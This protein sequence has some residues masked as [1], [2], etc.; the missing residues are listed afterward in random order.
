MTISLGGAQRARRG[1]LRPPTASDQSL[2][3]SLAR[4][5]ALSR[6]TGWL[7]PGRPPDRPALHHCAASDAPLSNDPRRLALSVRACVRACVHAQAALVAR[8]AP[9]AAA[10][11]GGGLGGSRLDAAAVARICSCFERY[12]LPTRLPRQL[13]DVGQM[14]CAVLADDL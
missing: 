1:R 9:A 8:D 7:G 3:R 10:G 2:A 4:P 11:A 5:R 14:L 12:G 13:Q 6:G